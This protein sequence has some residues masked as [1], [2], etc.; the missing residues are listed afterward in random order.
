MCVPPINKS[1]G[2]G[3]KMLSCFADWIGKVGTLGNRA[4]GSPGVNVLAEIPISQA[5]LFLKL[6]QPTHTS[7]LSLLAVGLRHG[8]GAARVSEGRLPSGNKA[9][10]GESPV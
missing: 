7:Y 2:P 5:Y 6:S 8:Q 10:K 4:L 1:Q 9:I 3:Y